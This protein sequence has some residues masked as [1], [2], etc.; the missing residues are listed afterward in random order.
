MHI[1]WKRYYKSGRAAIA[2]ESPY[3][4]N[5]IELKRM[6]WILRITYRARICSIYR[7]RCMRLDC[8]CE[9]CA[10]ALSFMWCKSFSLLLYI[11]PLNN[12]NLF[13]INKLSCFW[14][15]I[16]FARKSMCIEFI[17][18]LKN[19]IKTCVSN[20][21]GFIFLISFYILHFTK[22]EFQH[23]LQ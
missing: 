14:G 19:E 3:G 1:T 21:I 17:L 2:T 5:W 10:F 16:F 9:M 13:S 6:I 20:K 4:F 12:V 8:I 22:R 7:W 15:A 11:A 18:A 23:S